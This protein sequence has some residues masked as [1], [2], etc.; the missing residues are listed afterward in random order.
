MNIDAIKQTRN[1][2]T[3]ILIVLIL[4]IVL[5]VF[6]TYTFLHESGHAIVGLFFGQSLTEFN[7]SFWNFKAHVGMAGGELTPWQLAIRSAAGTVLPLLV[8]AIFINFIPRKASFSLELLK[9]LSSMTVVNTLLTWIV[10]PILFHLGKAPSDDVTNFLRYSQ[11]PPYFLIF[12]AILLYVGG[13]IVFLSKIDGFRNEFLLFRKTQDEALT[14]GART[15][16]SILT[17]IMMVCLIFIVTLNALAS[18]NSLRKF[19]PPQG[20][21]SVAQ[22]DLSKKTYSA[23]IL[24]SFS[25]ETSTYVGVFVAVHNIN[26]AYFDLRVVGPDRFS[27]IVLHGEGYNALQDGGLWE[28]NLPSGTYQVILTSRPSPGTASV[29]LKIY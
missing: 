17:V 27:S 13:W 29:Y 18:K 2:S 10:L 28:K 14:T 8:W 9:L 15:T 3:A 24:R 12:I 21:E 11:I 25:L 19:S 5:F 22:I 23:E 6:F 1:T 16:V 7:V 4:F 26:T 20:F